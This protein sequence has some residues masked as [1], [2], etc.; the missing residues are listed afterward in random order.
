MSII[1]LALFG[2]VKRWTNNARAGVLINVFL[3]F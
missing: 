2:S 1:V 3:S